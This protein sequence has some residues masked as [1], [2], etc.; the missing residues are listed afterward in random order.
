MKEFVFKVEKQFNN[1]KVIDFLK[2]KNL[3]KEIIKKIKFGGIFLNDNLVKDVNNLVSHLDSVKIVLPKDLKNKFIKKSNGNLEV[4]Y[5]DEYLVAVYKESGILTHSSKY[6]ESL[7]IEQLFYSKYEEEELSF[8]PINR[9]DKDTSGVL[10]LAKDMLT[11]SFMG[12]IIKSR[13]VEKIYQTVVVGT[14]SEN[15]FVIEKP[16]KKEKENN[17]KRC[18]SNDGQYAKTECFFVKKLNDNLSLLEVRLHTGRT[19]QIRVHLSYVRLPLYADSLYG[20]KVDGKSYILRATSIKFV[21][22]FLNKEILVSCP[23]EE[24]KIMDI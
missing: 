12:D 14:P 8:R 18:V 20:E 4:L 2:S 3:S 15:H 19:H 7:S 13:E 21:H 22:P 10:L 11:A 24:E 1:Y 6:N 9:L 16:I 23:L 5:E 17:V